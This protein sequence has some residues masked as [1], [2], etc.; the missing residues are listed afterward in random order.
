M[1]TWK[2]GNMEH[3]DMETMETWKHEKWRHG[4]I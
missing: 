1:E 2:H 4:D 3:G